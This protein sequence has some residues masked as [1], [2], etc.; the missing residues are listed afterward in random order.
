MVNSYRTALVVFCKYK[1]YLCVHCF[2]DKV[3]LVESLLQIFLPL[4]ELHLLVWFCYRLSRFASDRL[5]CLKA[6][7][8]KHL[9]VSLN[10]HPG[11]LVKIDRFI[12]IKSYSLS[13]GKIL[14]HPTNNCHFLLKTGNI[15]PLPLSLNH[16]AAQIGIL[17]SGNFPDIQIDPVRIA[18]LSNRM[19]CNVQCRHSNIFYHFLT[20][21]LITYSLLQIIEIIERTFCQSVC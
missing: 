5:A 19:R 9:Q 6:I 2:I 8:K 17:T 15:I 21:Q 16:S 1:E 3:H 20:F 4:V 12:G 18:S 7:K 14:R 11:W 13:K 10:R